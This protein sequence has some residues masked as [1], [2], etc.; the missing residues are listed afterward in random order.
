MNRRSRY[1]VS[2]LLAGLLFGCLEP[3]R[4]V[5]PVVVDSASAS[6]NEV[7]Q[8]N[9]VSTL[10][11]DSRQIT[12]KVISGKSWGSG[13]L[14][15]H[16]NSVYT[17]VTNQHVLADA[18][19]KIQ[20]ADGQIHTAQPYPVKA[21]Q[22]YDLA[23]LQFRS[24]IAY[25]IVRLGSAEP[26]K[27]GEAVFST[28]FPYNSQAVDATG[29][30]FTE[31]N[32]S[33]FAA[34]AFE[35]GYQLGYTN[36]VEK[37]MSGGPVLNQNGELVGI[38]GIHARPLWA[39]DRNYFDGSSPCAPLQNVIPEFSWAIP[40]ETF[41]RLLPK[42]LQSAKTPIIHPLT[43]MPPLASPTPTPETAYNVLVL[44]AKASAALNC[45]TPEAR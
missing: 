44:Q 5:L 21:F 8:Q 23:I 29:F 45:V 32:V 25:P 15:Q 7:P 38:N 13:V 41:L 19:Y 33:L 17:V 22:K 31:G 37:G 9:L 39:A 35:E 20:T 14:V 2:G 3:Q 12:V 43:T 34:K 30:K 24:P 16:Q 42:S 28:G 10:Q 18:P 1:V 11:T 4:A 27:V 26:L 6:N 36:D 40:T